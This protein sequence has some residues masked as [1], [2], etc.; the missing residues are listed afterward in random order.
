MWHLS[1]HIFVW[2]SNELA[3]LGQEEIPTGVLA[4]G[5]E[6]RETLL[7]AQSWAQPTRPTPHAFPLSP[8]PSA[9]RSYISIIPPMLAVRTRGNSERVIISTSIVVLLGQPSLY[10]RKRRCHALSRAQF[11]QHA[12]LAG[13]LCFCDFLGFQVPVS[14]PGSA[15][16]LAAKATSWS[17]LILCNFYFGNMWA[18][19]IWNGISIL[20]IIF[21]PVQSTIPLNPSHCSQQKV[22][23]C[24]VST[25]LRWRKPG[26][27]SNWSGGIG[28]WQT[29]ATTWWNE[30]AGIFLWFPFVQEASIC[31]TLNYPSRQCSCNGKW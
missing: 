12:C 4:T 9:L 15:W 18:F 29:R 13:W 27:G 2:S 22:E 21:H 6:L 5:Q 28:Q 14:K 7:C 10:S 20:S 24:N 25:R 1:F 3:F 30:V 11:P 8:N 19:L 17:S 23:I 16:S 31:P 26:A